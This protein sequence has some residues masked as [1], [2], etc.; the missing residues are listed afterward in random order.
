MKISVITSTPFPKGLAATN[1]ITNYCLG[2]LEHNIQPFVFTI[3]STNTPQDPYLSKGVYKNI[4]YSYASK[5]E[6]PKSFV[7]R[8]LNDIK[9]LLLSCKYAYKNDADINYIYINSNLKELILIIASK[10]GGKKVVRELCEYPY[11]KK[12]FQSWISQA[13]ILPLYDGHVAISENL[14]ILGNKK[15][16]QKAKIIKVPIL[17]DSSNKKIAF[18]YSHRRPYIFHGGTLT[19]SKDAIISTMK[20]FVI[21]NKKL[22]KKIDFILAGPTSSDLNELRTIIKDNQLEDN[23][24]FLG[25]LTHDEVIKYQ[26]GATLSILNKKDTIQNQYGFSTKLGD[27]L[28]AGTPLITTNIGEA[29]NWLVDGESAYITETNNIQLLAE[30]ILE[31]FSD[32]SKRKNIGL[33]GQQVALQSFDIVFHGKRL[34][35]FFENILAK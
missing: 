19:E 29:N 35:H 26:K 2:L 28:L 9:D 31:A 18:E 4:Q 7:K 6:R 13:F 17:I 20:A 10:L 14:F 24:I 23:V 27:I 33:K 12:C 22:R 21:V 5:S 30:K 8:R 25:Q 11:Y 1:R 32:E 15:K 16:S 34:K 3:H